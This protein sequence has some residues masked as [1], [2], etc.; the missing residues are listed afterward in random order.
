MKASIE[1]PISTVY[2]CL[3][4][5]QNNSIQSLFLSSFPGQLENKSIKSPSEKRQNQNEFALEL[6]WQIELKMLVKMKGKSADPLSGIIHS[7]S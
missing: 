4:I 2:I 7:I 6:C 5:H 3:F 1:N